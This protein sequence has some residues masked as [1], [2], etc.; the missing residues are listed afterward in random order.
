MMTC[1]KCN[2]RVYIDRVFSQK[3]RIELYC[4]MCGKRWF[5]KK[6]GNAFGEWLEKLEKKH[7]ADYCIST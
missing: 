4:L 6:Q 5:V 2:G 7:N 1:K 3:T